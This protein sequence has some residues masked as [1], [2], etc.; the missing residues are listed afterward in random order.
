MLGFSDLDDGIE[1][2]LLVISSVP[3][4]LGQGVH[5]VLTSIDPFYGHMTPTLQVTFHVSL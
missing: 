2:Y 3:S 1:F 5:Y 4:Y